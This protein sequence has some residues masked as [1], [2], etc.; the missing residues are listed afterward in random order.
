MLTHWPFL[1]VGYSE[2]RFGKTTVN[3]RIGR[4]FFDENGGCLVKK[5]KK[6]QIFGYLLTVVY[7]KSVIL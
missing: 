6:M 4:S 1:F 5:A 7:R 3:L 2:I